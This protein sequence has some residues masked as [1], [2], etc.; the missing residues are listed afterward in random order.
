[1]ELFARQVLPVFVA[2][3]TAIGAWDLLVRVTD[4]P[5][6]LLPAP[7]E[8]AR[9]AWEGRSL[10]ARHLVATLEIAVAGFCIGVVF[11]VGI[12]IALS[13][14]TMLRRAVEP[15]LIASQAIPPVVFAPVLI[16]T[17][18]FAL[19]SKVL[20]VAVGA[21]FPVAVSAIGAMRTAD[22]YLI[23]L[24][25]AMGASP[26]AVLRRVRLPAAAPAIAA[27][28]RV[29]ATYVMFSAI[30]AEWMGSSMGLGVYL[31]RS[32]AAYRTDQIFAAVFVIAALGVLLFWLASLLEGLVLARFRPAPSRKAHL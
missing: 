8:V 1:V 17:L 16:A 3:A 32:Q 26:L 31:Q 29:S 28:A 9:T 27:G 15:V 19:W 10:L 11:G 7:A 13:L 4:A 21:F 18:G 14:S 12:A 30:I 24:M 6:Y 23:D 22:R 25:V 5:R 2:A 20:V